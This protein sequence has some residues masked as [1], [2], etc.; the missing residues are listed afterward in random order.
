MPNHY[1][2]S[3]GLCTRKVA[4]NIKCDC[5][6]RFFHVKCANINTKEF[7]ALNSNWICFD[8]KTQIFPFMNLIDANFYE[9][10]TEA[11]LKKPCKCKTCFKRINVGMPFATCQ[12]CSNFFHKGCANFPTQ[13]WDCN[14]CTLGNLPFSNIN[15]NDF[16]VNLLGLD[17]DSSDFLRNVPS[18]SIQS[19]IN[20]IPGE[21]FDT[22]EF[23]SDSITSKYYTPA[24]FI[25]AKLPKNKF[26]IIHLN[27]ASL[28]A[29]IDELRQLLAILN[30]PFDAICISETRFHEDTPLINYQIENYD[31]FYEKKPYTV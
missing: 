23:L 4:R 6:K 17:D 5:C 9:A 1:I 31:F 26:S 14:S 25:S 30:H 15:N 2:D 12:K 27:I 19:L 21:H 13:K 29:H 8:C 22:N 24:E 3:C 11:V 7:N 20:Q 28:S 18:F 10:F 16:M